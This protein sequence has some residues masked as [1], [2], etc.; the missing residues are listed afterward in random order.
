ME[1]SEELKK[2][3]KTS[4]QVAECMLTKTYPVVNDPKL[5]LAIAGDIYTALV[6]GMTAL[7]THEKQE[8]KPEFNE[9]NDFES[10]FNAFKEIAS[11]NGF[12]K[13]EVALVSNIHNIM[14]EHKESPV[15]FARKDRFVICDE[16]YR[17]ESLSLDDMKSYLFKARLFIEKTES[18]IDGRENK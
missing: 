15:E 5:I 10:K 16:N 9:D 14:S 11:N 17:C 1:S 2:R 18:I 12:T 13:D 6:S 8:H 7:I 4:L 3:A